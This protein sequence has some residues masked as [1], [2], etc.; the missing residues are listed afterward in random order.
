LVN[1]TV[2]AL[3]TMMKKPHASHHARRRGFKGEGHIHQ[4]MN[5][6]TIIQ[7]TCE[8]RV[9]ARTAWKA[10]MMKAHVTEGCAANER[11]AAMSTGMAMQWTKQST[12]LAMPIRSARRPAEGAGASMVFRSTPYGTR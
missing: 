9:A 10:M 1:V 11:P 8:R 12:V 2:A 3:R 7:R 4:A 5:I 6:G